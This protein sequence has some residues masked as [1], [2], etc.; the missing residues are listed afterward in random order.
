M[1]WPPRR[2]AEAAA[3]F[4]G[5]T[6][7][8]ALVFTVA[9]QTAGPA[10]PLEYIIFPFAIWAALRF[11]QRGVSALTLVAPVIVI[12]GTVRRVGPFSGGTIHESLILLHV[13]TA[14]LAITGLIL[15]AI[16]VERRRAEDA[17]RD[18]DRR[19]DEFLATLATSCNPLA[20]IRNALHLLT[21]PGVE[22]A[23]AQR[24]RE[25]L[26]RQVQ[27]LVRLV[28]DL[29]DVSRIMR[30]RIELRKERMELAVAVSRAV[31]IAQ[32]AIEAAGHELTI[33]LPAEPILLEADPVRL[34]QVIANL[35][36][37]AAK[38]TN[39]RGHIRLC[40]EREGQ[41]AVI[42]VRDSGVGI[43]PEML[44]PIFDLFVQADHS[45]DRTQGGMG[46]GLTLA[47]NWPNCT[48]ARLAR[49]AKD[50]AREASLSCDFRSWC[51]DASPK[52][53]DEYASAK[54]R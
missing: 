6:A 29:L 16:I 35:L 4:L 25:M 5:L 8:C 46:I 33:T 13:Y 23:T 3:L 12:V 27:Y 30:N 41:E 39:Q 7:V 43:A 11:G 51:G 22:G 49:S 44:S 28:D 20:P 34:V 54:Q 31:E 24:A 38:Y 40:A 15:A 14:V 32:P 45:L 50:R 53:V 48:A 18:A 1:P 9:G 47:R 17:L 2:L 26:Q 21:L 42:R 10:Y 52:R 36:N 19:K 37:N